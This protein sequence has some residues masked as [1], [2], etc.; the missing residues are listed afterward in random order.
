MGVGTQFELFP[1][2]AFPGGRAEFGP[3][4][5][6]PYMS[7]RSVNSIPTTAL[8]S[9][10]SALF[11]EV[12]Y[13]VENKWVARTVKS[14]SFNQLRTLSHSFPASPSLSICS[15]NQRGVYPSLPKN[16]RSCNSVI[17]SELQIARACF[18]WKSNVH[19]ILQ[20]GYRGCICAPSSRRLFFG[21]R[22]ITEHRNNA[23]DGDRHQHKKYARERKPRNCPVDPSRAGQS[24]HHKPAQNPQDGHHAIPRNVESPAR[25]RPR[26]VRDQK[27]A[28]P[29]QRQ[30]N[31]QP[32]SVRRE[33]FQCRRL[34][35]RG[36]EY[37]GH[38][39][40]TYACCVPK[41]AIVASGENCSCAQPL[42][43]RTGVSGLKT[44]T[45]EGFRR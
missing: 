21:R 25:C 27:H 45:W 3:L 9:G 20:I 29:D 30:C 4:I 43:S 24:S 22:P 23:P 17:F 35:N 13:L 31:R 11:Q 19:I 36:L 6:V 8:F 40:C 12:S 14:L 42:S 34:S 18:S 26:N 39:N 16:D 32:G 33:D 7:T 44:F 37:E 15:P 41:R 5:S 1:A 2:P 38:A 10:R 28:G